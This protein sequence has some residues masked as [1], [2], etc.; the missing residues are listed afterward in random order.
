MHSKSH[1][2]H[3]HV[4]QGHLPLNNNDTENFK[5]SNACSIKC[6][7]QIA[8]IASK[9]SGFNSHGFLFQKL[10]TEPV[11]SIHQWKQWIREAVESIFDII[12]QKIVHQFDVCSGTFG[13]Y[14]EFANPIEKHFDLFFSFICSMY[15]YSLI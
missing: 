5:N 7:W 13:A 6:L 11:H 14:I 10:Y 9:L 12:L 8:P 15:L 3:N 4:A 2:G 1:V